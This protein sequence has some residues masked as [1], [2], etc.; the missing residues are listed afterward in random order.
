MAGRRSR[1]RT[2]PARLLPG[3]AALL[4]DPG[5]ATRPAGAFPG[6]AVALADPH[7]PTRPASETIATP[8]STTA[9]PAT[10]RSPTRSPRKRIARIVAQTGMR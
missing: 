1:T 5:L 4:A 8:A 6:G 9:P 10:S 7:L 2:R 3:G